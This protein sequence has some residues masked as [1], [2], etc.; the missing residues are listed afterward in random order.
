MTGFG[1]LIA[2]Y[3]KSPQPGAVRPRLRRFYLGYKDEGNYNSLRLGLFAGCL[4]I[5][6]AGESCTDILTC[7][8]IADTLVGDLS[9][10]A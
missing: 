9:A 5:V 3:K 8:G 4:M 10:I 2:N 6:L 7:D 1:V